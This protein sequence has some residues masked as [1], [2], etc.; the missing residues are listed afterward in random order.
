MLYIL[1]ELK[2]EIPGV[3]VIWGVCLVVVGEPWSAS[4]VGYLQITHSGSVCFCVSTSVICCWY[5][6]SV[7][8]SATHVL[9]YTGWYKVFE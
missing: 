4:H 8:I 3:L 7:F 1:Y 9:Y 6:T 2:F 5:H